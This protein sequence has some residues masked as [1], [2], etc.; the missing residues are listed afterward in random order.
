VNELA[1]SSSLLDAMYPEEPQRNWKKYSSWVNHD[2]I[3]SL[4]HVLELEQALVEA[5]SSP[6][7][8]SLDCLESKLMGQEQLKEFCLYSLITY[9]GK[10]QS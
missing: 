5:Y 8:V 7:E 6:A 4:P 10:V 3:S 2:Q 9:F 1:F